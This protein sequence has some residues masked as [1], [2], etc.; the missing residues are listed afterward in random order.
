[1]A[2]ILRDEEILA[3]VTRDIR[4][5]LHNAEHAFHRQMSL[6]AERFD[7]AAG[8]F[9]KEHLVDLR[10]VAARVIDILTLADAEAAPELG[11]PVVLLARALT[12]SGLSQFAPG[13]LLGLCL[14]T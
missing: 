8:G 13:K 5:N 3:A 1:H 12:P 10:D 2:L 14:E 9:L 6:L 11:A 7:A 4:E